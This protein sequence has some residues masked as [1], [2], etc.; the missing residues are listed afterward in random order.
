VRKTT[1]ILLIF[2]FCRYQ[3]LSSGKY[4]Y[5][6]LNTIQKNRFHIIEYDWWTIT[7]DV[8]IPIF[9]LWKIELEVMSDW[10]PTVIASGWSRGE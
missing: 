1:T 5:K 2:H 7:I 6:I 10:L 9:T 3:R 4:Q 8:F